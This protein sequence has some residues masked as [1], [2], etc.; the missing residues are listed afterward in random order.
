MLTWTLKA[1]ANANSSSPPSR[2]CPARMR[3][4]L[5]SVDNV[6]YV[7]NVYLILTT[8]V[9]LNIIKKIIIKLLFYANIRYLTKL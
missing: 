1:S 5:Q 2:T 6:F 8:F 3:S 9:V 7:I 4:V